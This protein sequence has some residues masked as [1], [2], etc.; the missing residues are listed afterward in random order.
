MLPL[1]VLKHSLKHA[2]FS[3]YVAYTCR[4]AVSQVLKP[5][6]I[7]KVIGIPIPEDV[8]EFAKCRFKK[9]SKFTITFSGGLTPAKGVYDFINAVH[10]LARQ[11]KALD[12][13]ALIFGYGNVTPIKEYIKKLRL[14]DFIKV[15]GFVKHKEQLKY[16]AE[17]NLLVNPSYG[18]GCP[19]VVLEA[20]ALGTPVLV[21]NAPGNVDLATLFGLSMAKTGD[22]IDLSR[23]MLKIM[24]NY[25]VYKKKVETVRSQVLKLFRPENIARRHL[26]LYKLALE[27]KI[28]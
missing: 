21:S 16:L 26:R 10:Y 20:L 12:F 9:R 14:V 19:T 4:D 25:D 22:L 24:N 23:K 7:T 2:S 8:V 28:N 11:R 1:L 27:T 15:M 17:S 18:E 6:N 5:R 3:T 13:E